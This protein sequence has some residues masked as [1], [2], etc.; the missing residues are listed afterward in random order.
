M[1]IARTIKDYRNAEQALES[2]GVIYDAQGNYTQ[3]IDCYEQRLAIAKLA[4]DPGLEQQILTSLRSVCYAVGDYA[5]A[6]RY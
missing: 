1:V 4:Q 5:R 2:L 3:A 6:S